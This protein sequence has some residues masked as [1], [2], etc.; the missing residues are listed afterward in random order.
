MIDV[1]KRI[2]LVDLLS[3][4]AEIEHGLMCQYLF[5]A[6]S[7]KRE[8]A[9]GVMWAQL[10]H[11]RRWGAS[12]MLVARQ[13]MEHLGLVNNMLAA[14]GEGPC[15]VR[16]NFPLG[17]RHYAIDIP[18]KL[19]R[20][21]TDALARFVEFEMPSTL[22]PEHHARLHQVLPQIGGG[23][24][25][26]I[27]RLYE[28]IAD[29]FGQ[30]DSPELWI[31]P[32]S[33]QFSTT[34]VIPVPLRGISLPP[35]ARIYDIELMPVT[36]LASAKAVVAQVLEEG[37]GIPT[38]TPT[39]HYARFLVIAEEL[40]ALRLAD[41]SFDPARDVLE[42]PRGKITNLGTRQVAELFELAYGT[43]MLMLMRYFAHADE[44]AAARAALQRTAFF[45]LMTTVLRPLGEMLTRLP[46]TA[47][48][49]TPTAG[50]TFDFTRNITPH[51]HR[52]T[53][54]R[55]ILGQIEQMAADAQRLSGDASYPAD[56]RARLGLVYEN[57]ARMAI[58]FAGAMNLPAPA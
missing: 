6:F 19:E 5:A 1:H 57:L 54:W 2:R 21:G 34:D 20:F 8:P 56:I 17:A 3:E 11:M 46:A 16:P 42:N 53:A 48:A 13:E 9:E 27:A 29:L 51:P 12:V 35:N 24:F 37:E 7:L 36:D 43:T 26:T 32:P 15:F 45:P 52:D 49:A 31:G 18:F 44:D 55:V 41:P 33:A 25:Q 14:I 23:R 39:S 40:V 30:L 22:D 4:V 28:E 47:G 10:E 38:P 50:P 58:N